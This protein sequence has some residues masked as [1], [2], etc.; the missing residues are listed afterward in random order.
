MNERRWSSIPYLDA[1][2]P[3][4]GW[5]TDFALLASYSADLIALV[6]ALLALAGVDDDRG[7]GSKV[8]F[9]NA[10]EQLKDR[11]RLLAQCG[12][13]LAPTKTP[14]I[15]AILDR[16][17]REVAVDEH[18][19]SWHPKIAISRHMA[20][21]GGAVQWRLWIGSRNL[22]R[23]ISWD[24][25][26]TVIGHVGSQG[27]QVA[28]IDEIGYALVEHA[29]LPGISAAKVR[30]ELRAVRWTVPAGCRLRSAR[31]CRSDEARDLP[32]MPQEIRKLIVVSPFLDGTIV[33]SL[34]KWGDENTARHLLSTRTELSKLA[35]QAG[36]PLNGYRELL[37]V[38]APNVDES[39][40]DDGSDAENA[41][42]N[43]E[44][45]EGRGLHA[46]IIYAEHAGG[47]TIWTGSAN[48][49]RR[50]WQGPNNEVIAELEVDKDIAQGL[51]A[52][53][54]DIGRTVGRS[55]LT[56]PDERD[57]I[58][59]RL[60]EARK[61]IASHWAIV[62]R[63]DADGMFLDGAADLHPADLQVEFCAG[64]LG[65]ALLVWPR[66]ESQLR[67]PSVLPG[68]VT[69][70]VRCRLR[71]N[72]VEVSW[73]QRTPIDPAPG[74]ERDRQA[75]ARFL[76]PRTFLLWIR[77]LLGFDEVGDGGGDWDGDSTSSR[78][79]LSSR[80]GPT[81]W[82]PTIEEVLKAWSR[83]PSSLQLVDRKVRHYLKLYES[84]VDADRTD[85]DRRVVEQFHETWQVVRRELIRETPE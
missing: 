11:V 16:F 75:L 37:Y 9:A 53:V 40:V 30:A 8:D 14:K 50:G 49:T 83:D 26:L 33:K 77:S 45:L 73:L 59:D 23:D 69:E 25:G 38:D 76:D 71:L 85:E 6:A 20:E 48:A 46:K 4:P 36:N 57:E 74:D 62:L 41:R 52:F 42:S 68:E 12:R 34:G 51:E 80:A 78:A 22:T 32:Q 13:L 47:R 58:R 7:S 39:R 65:G 55:E 2:R 63:T 72:D 43:D 56:K 70:F 24:T 5:R 79:K 84:Q 44:E 17:V 29:A 82:A 67:L 66:G 60:E 1:I 3:D 28:G 19:A 31:L 27:Q 54:A 61:H 35:H 18:A 81:W 64:L 21:D 10:I 15:M